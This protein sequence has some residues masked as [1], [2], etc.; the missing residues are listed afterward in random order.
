LVCPEEEEE[1]RERQFILAR[2]TRQADFAQE[3]VK[4]FKKLTQA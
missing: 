4:E 3:V 2:M 1:C